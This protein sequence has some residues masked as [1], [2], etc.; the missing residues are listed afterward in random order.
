MPDPPVL[1]LDDSTSALDAGTAFRL[2]KALK[3]QR[4]HGTTLIIAQ[5]VAS[6]WTA[7]TIIVLDDG[8]IVDNAPHSILLERCSLYRE[9][10]QSQMGEEAIHG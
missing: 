8:R 9:I 4:T 1:I 3:E 2:Q 10:V 7:D 5:R 6:I